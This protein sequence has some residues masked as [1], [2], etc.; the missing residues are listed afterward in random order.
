MVK[1]PYLVY[2]QSQS[3]VACT[4]WRCV[5]LG[6]KKKISD[7]SVC[8]DEAE[9]IDC[10]RYVESTAPEKVEPIPIVKASGI[11]VIGQPKTVVVKDPTRPKAPVPSADCPYLGPVPEGEVAC[12]GM[13]C[14]STY[15]PIRTG[16]TCQ[17]RPSWQECKH[18]FS[19]HRRGVKPPAS[20]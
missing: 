16:T 4:G 9:W 19:A 2:E 11:G 20:S 15:G 8:M 5:S 6:R 3:C 18:V 12:C 14:Y 1:C 17:S 13:W 7:N 10:V